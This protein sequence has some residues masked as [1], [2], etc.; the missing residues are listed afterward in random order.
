MQQTAT[1]VDQVKRMSSQNRIDTRN[2]AQP[3]SQ[4]INCDKTFIDGSPH[5]IRPRTITLPVA[6]ITREPQLG[7]FKAVYLINGNPHL[8]F[9]G[10]MENVSLRPA[11]YLTSPD[12]IS[13]TAGAGKTILWFVNPLLFLS[14]TAD[15]VYHFQFYNHRRYPSQVRCRSSLDG[16]LL[17]RLSKHQQAALA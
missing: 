16:L 4:G 6:L 14:K 11:F 13:C 9:S 10:S 2:V 17:F 15:V 3:S 5:Q 8:R 1:E 12:G 7:S